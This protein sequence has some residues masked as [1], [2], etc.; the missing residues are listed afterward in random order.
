MKRFKKYTGREANRILNRKGQRFWQREW[1]DHWSRTP[2]EDD[3][4]IS[5]IRNNPVH[6]GL[7]ENAEDWP[8]Q[9]Q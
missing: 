7:V 9:H 8:W 6:A 5:Y 2:Q 4:I 3:K 1:F